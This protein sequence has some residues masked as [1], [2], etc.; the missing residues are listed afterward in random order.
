MQPVETS[1]RRAGWFLRRRDLLALGHSDTALRRALARKRIFRVRHGWYSVPAAPAAGVRA[2]RVGGRLTGLPALEAYGIPVPR[3][4]VLHVAVPANACRLRRPGDRRARLTE[5]DG[6]ALSWNDRARREHASPWRVPM[7]DALLAVLE[8]EPRDIA[9][10]CASAIMRRRRWSRARIAAVFDRAPARA[11]CW[12]ALVSPL[13]DSHGETFVRLWLADAGIPTTSQP[14]VAGVGHLDF[15]L[16]PNVYLEVDGAQHDPSWTGESA[17]SYESDHDRDA[18]VA[19][20]GGT[21]LR[22]T[23]RQLYGNW[24]GCLAAIER[25]IADDRELIARRLRDPV[26]PRAARLPARAVRRKRRN[27]GAIGAHK[28]VWPP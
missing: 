12:L 5:V 2:V 26:V 14:Y 16:S 23:Y 21:T 8:H 4:Q 25:S 3:S 19:A 11:A 9:V 1:I 18:I 13:D 15:R 27:A 10:A 7:G 17:S 6:I 28:G 22:F 20:D 24:A